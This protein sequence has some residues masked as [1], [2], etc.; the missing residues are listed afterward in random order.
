MYLTVL[1]IQ[2]NLNPNFKKFIKT[3][4]YY[5]ILNI[6]YTFLYIIFHQKFLFEVRRTDVK[7]IKKARYQNTY[8]DIL[9]LIKA[10]SIS[11]SHPILS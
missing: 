2:I 5:F 11:I 7:T 9:L 8:I 4:F 1:G 10:F 3:S 6:L